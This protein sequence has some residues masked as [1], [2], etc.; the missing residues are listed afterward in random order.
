MNNPF[1]R[2][3]LILIGT[4]GFVHVS[5]SHS[6]GNYFSDSMNFRGYETTIALLFI[7]TIILAKHSIL[8]TGICLLLSSIG[9]LTYGLWRKTIGTAV[10]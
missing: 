5:L 7:G 8:L 6:K 3:F 2:V 1:V 4:I 10:N 9:V